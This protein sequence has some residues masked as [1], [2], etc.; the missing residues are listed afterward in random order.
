MPGARTPGG[1]SPGD[2][3]HGRAGPSG[4]APRRLLVVAASA[5][6]AVSGCRDVGSGSGD[7]TVAPPSAY[8]DLPVTLIVTA[9]ALRPALAIDIADES[10]GFEPG[11]I[12]MSLVGATPG[13][14]VPLSSPR[15]DGVETYLTT[16]PAGTAPGRYGLRIDTADGRATMV[17][18]AFQ[19]LGPDMDPPSLFVEAPMDDAILPAGGVGMLRV[20]ADD[21]PGQLARVSWDTSAGALGFCDLPPDQITGQ[22]PGQVTCRQSF[23]VPAVPDEAVTPQAFAL[24]VLATDVVGHTTA[25]NVPLLAAAPPV[26]TE[27]EGSIGALAGNQPFVVYGKHFL[28]GSRAAL[29]GIL[30]LGSV[31]GGDQADDMT[32]MGLTP[33]HDPGVVQVSVQSRAGIDYATAPFRYVAPP[34]PRLVNPAVGPTGGGIRVTVAGNDLLDSVIIAFG[35]TA[36][37]AQPL[38]G[39]S[40]EAEDKVVGCLPPGQGTV[41]VWAIDP[42][43]GMGSLPASFTYQDS[44][45]DAGVL[46]DPSCASATAP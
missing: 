26:I 6:A 44:P 12:R 11:S 17:T 30:I 34:R 20:I 35:A 28:P 46:L 38:G 16:V 8:S 45:S 10:A 39:V 14:V 3:R 42:V 25:V 2:R 19:E 31:A 21:G 9:P 33:P 5:V 23:S 24:H 13:D 40:H 18:A 41:S 27:F 7:V 15:W 4:S 37:E 32:I 22:P 43:T 36:A 1:R 29:D